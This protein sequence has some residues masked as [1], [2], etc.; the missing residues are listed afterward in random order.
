MARVLITCITGQ[1]GSY[2]AE[3]LLS[4]G[5]RVIGMVRRSSAATPKGFN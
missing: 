4:K 2:L 5:N 1:G 3:L